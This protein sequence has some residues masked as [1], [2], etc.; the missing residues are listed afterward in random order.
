MVD[1]FDRDGEQVEEFAIVHLHFDGGYV[2]ANTWWGQGPNGI[3]LS[4]SAGYIVHFQN[5]RG[6]TALSQVTV[7]R[8]DGAQTHRVQTS[9]T[10]PFTDSFVTVHRDFVQAI[11]E[12]KDPVAPAKAGMTALEGVIAAYASAA[13][14][15]IVHLPLDRGGSPFKK[16]AAGIRDLSIR[17]DS[18]VCK[19]RLFG[20]KEC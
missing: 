10:D 3:E 16:G 4:G 6:D 17:P 18:P 8:S 15:Q 7:V 20:L 19:R 12:N 1:N 9:K 11:L 2:T 5:S 14:G 13:T